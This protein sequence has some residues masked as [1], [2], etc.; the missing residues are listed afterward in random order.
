MCRVG[1]KTVQGK[2][3]PGGLLITCRLISG[4]ISTISMRRLR[5]GSKATGSPFGHC[6]VQAPSGCSTSTRGAARPFGNL[7]EDFG[8]FRGTSGPHIAP[9]SGMLAQARCASAPPW[10][11]SHS[12]RY[13]LS[14]GQAEA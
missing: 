2:P 5:V 8:G 14:E 4:A 1:W 12:H 10:S 7:I 13:D 9:V 6:R 11:K 3:V